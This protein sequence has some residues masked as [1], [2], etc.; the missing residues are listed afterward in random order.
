M[1]R[2]KNLCL[3]LFAVSTA[4]GATP[5]AAD[6]AN[7]TLVWAT[8][9]EI[10]SADP[11]Y[12]PQAE[13]VW[14]NLANCDML[15]WRDIKTGDYKPLLAESWNWSNEKTLDMVIRKGIKFHDGRDFGPEDVA[16]TL[17]TVSQP[18]SGIGLRAVVSWIDHV[19]VTGP[20]TIRIHAKSPTPQAL[21]LLSGLVPIYPKGHYDTAPVITG[22]DG[23]VR[24]DN[25]AVLPVC[26]GPY[27]LVDY[28]AGQSLTLVK[29]DQYFKESPKGQPQIGK[30]VFRVI[31]D[32]DTQVSE[33]LTGGIDWMWGV[34]SEN[35]KE[36][37]LFPKVTVKS[38]GS[39]RFSFLNFDSAQRSGDNP[40]KDVR[41]RRAIFHSIDRNAIAKQLIGAGAAAVKAMCSPL[42]VGCAQDVPDYPY[43]L[44]KAKAL[45]AEAGYPNGLKFK[46]YAYRDKP[47]VE[48]VINYMRKAGIDAELNFM[49]YP[50]FVPISNAG[51]MEIRMMSWGSSGILDISS[52]TGNFFEGSLEDYARDK[53]VIDALHAGDA[54]FDAAK[55]NADYKVALSR[56]NEEALGMPLYSY[57]R[58][59]A[60]NSELDFPI[61]EDDNN[62]FFLARWK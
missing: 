40:L 54:E 43:D 2:F 16:Y 7:D 47:Y 13:A 52:S 28:K 33:L 1:I 56:I 42:Q 41:V 12:A 14:T 58:I 25:G 18:D 3:T 10:G 27:K 46:L 24:H 26:T 55:R 22:A 36:L 57:G 11:Y 32:T 35:A 34:P 9:G 5:A 21:A 30:I 20:D 31:P 60:Y 59:Y 48:A 62:Y 17:N 39:I 8:S 19:D 15:I 23:K 37:A 29:N 38:G 4:L 6:K 44:A 51:K 45:L 53:I 49:Q 61:T 50:A